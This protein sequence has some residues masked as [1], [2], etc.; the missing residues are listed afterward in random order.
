M[1]QIT[2]FLMFNGHA[3]EAMKLYVSLFPDSEILEIERYGED[4]GEAEGSVKH[5]LMSLGGQ[6]FR[7]IDTPV[8]HA[9]N[10]TPA[11]S[12]YVPCDT[13]SEV[14]TLFEKLSDEGQVLM[15]LDTY[16]FSKKYAWISDRYGV[17]WQLTLAES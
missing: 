12:L 4:E 3:E 6:W 11:M 1:Q 7:C 15:P 9:L 13:E 2:T 8:P 14:E 5:A 16:P 17:S 10:F